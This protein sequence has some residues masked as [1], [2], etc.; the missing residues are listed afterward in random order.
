MSDALLSDDK[1]RFTYADYKAWELAP[2]ERF[3]LIYGEPYAM[4]A[5]NA[6]HQ[7]IL[8]VL[9]AKFYNFLE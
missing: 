1:R 4:A 8:A 9:T 3:E 2:G 7:E 6:Y 5:P